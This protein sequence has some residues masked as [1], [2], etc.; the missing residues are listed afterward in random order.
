MALADRSCSFE[1]DVQEIS[2]FS[3]MSFL[4][5]RG[6]LDYAGPN[7]PLAIGVVVVLPSFLEER[8]RHPVPSHFRSSIAR[9]TNT[10]VY[11]STGTSR[12]RLQD[13]RPGWIR[14]SPFL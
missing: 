1:Q 4:S 8:S 13:S 10:S 5:V 3:C 12:C 9:P 7:N 11:A 14:C 6:F 2:R